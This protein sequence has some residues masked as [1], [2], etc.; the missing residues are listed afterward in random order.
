MSVEDYTVG[1]LHGAFLCHEVHGLQGLVSLDLLL[2]LLDQ[3]NL[4]ELGYLFSNALIVE[5]IL[6][7]VKQALLCDFVG[8]LVT[9]EVLRDRLQSDRLRLKRLFWPSEPRFLVLMLG[10][11][12][13]ETYAP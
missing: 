1:D 5:Q 4:L 3:A 8:I 10:L 13:V 7:P 9:A 12:R 11:D 2:L 6:H